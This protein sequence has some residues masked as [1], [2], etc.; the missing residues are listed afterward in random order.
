[1]LLLPHF[2]GKRNKVYI[3]EVMS[4]SHSTKHWIQDWDVRSLNSRAQL[5]TQPHPVP[6]H[7]GGH[8]EVYKIGSSHLQIT[9]VGH[10][11]GNVMFS[12]ESDLCPLYYEN[13]KKSFVKLFK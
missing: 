12:S 8:K 11:K 7:H 13:K 2:T 4:G 1:M 10:Q 9:G 5:I 3:N 6:Q